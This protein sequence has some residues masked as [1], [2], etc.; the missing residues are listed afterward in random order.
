MLEDLGP[1]SRLVILQS[2]SQAIHYGKSHRI[3]SDL[4]LGIGPEALHHIDKMGWAA[5]DLNELFVLSEYQKAGKASQS[6]IDNLIS[7]L[8]QYSL[9]YKPQ[10]ELHLGNYFAFQLWVIIAQIHYNYFIIRSIA[11]TLPRVNL[12]VYTKKVAKPFMDFRPDPD[13][14]FADVLVRSGLFYD[15]RIEIQRLTEGENNV[16]LQKKIIKT[17]PRFFTECLRNARVLWQIRNFGRP[18]NKLLLIGGRYDWLKIAR[19]KTFS[20]S[21]KLNIFSWIKLPPRRGAPRNLIEILN[22]SVTEKKKVVYDLDD[23]AG[24]IYSYL[25]TFVIIDRKAKNKLSQHHALVTSVLSHPLDLFLAHLAAKMNLPLIVWQHGEKGQSEDATALYTEL[26]YATSYWAYGPKVADQYRR[27]IGQNRLE[28]VAVVGSLGKSISWSGGETIV[29]ATGKWFKTASSLMLP[30]NPDQR[31]FI[32]HKT[33]LNYLNVEASDSPIVLKANNTE[34]LNSIP[35]KYENVFI[36]YETPFTILLR[37]AKLVILD[38]PAT[39]LVEACSTKVPIF[40]LG[41]RMN[42]C[43]DFL[44][45]VK[46]RVVWCETP[47]ELVESVR[48]FLRSGAYDADVDDNSY[49]EFYGASLSTGEVIANVTQNLRNEIEPFQRDL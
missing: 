16:G 18:S 7:E 17:L 11:D 21:F 38:T 45:L 30:P 49:V 41:G 22:Q 5:C 35:Y 24:S 37:N 48:A 6:K 47:S 19:Y 46:R 42:Y 40:V 10:L 13:S 12:L 2:S 26:Y 29:Y 34:G 23:L 1:V 4:V 43:G 36:D 20:E 14:I 9:S 33:I 32:A 39:T 31:L 28:R 27:S 44:A 8:N 25:N 3:E 15:D